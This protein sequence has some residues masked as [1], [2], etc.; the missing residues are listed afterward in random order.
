MPKETCA[1][2]LRGSRSSR[3]H[4]YVIQQVSYDAVT[5]RQVDVRSGIIHGSSLAEAS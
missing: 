2:V 1:K 5:E 3:S 4:L